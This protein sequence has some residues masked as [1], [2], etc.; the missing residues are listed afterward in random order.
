MVGVAKQA[1]DLPGERSNDKVPIVVNLTDE[2]DT[3]SSFSSILDTDGTWEIESAA[4]RFDVYEVLHVDEAEASMYKVKTG[5][6]EASKEIEQ[7]PSTL[8]YG[9]MHDEEVDWGFDDPKIEVDKEIQLLVDRAMAKIQ[10]KKELSLFK[11]QSMAVQA[12]HEDEPTSFA[13]EK[14]VKPI[15]EE[16]VA[17]MDI[18]D[19]DEAAEH[20]DK[21]PCDSIFWFANVLKIQVMNGLQ[22]FG[23]GQCF[24]YDPACGS[25]MYAMVA[26]RPDIA[27]AVGVVSRFMSIPGKKHWDAVKSILIPVVGG[28]LSIKGYVDSDYAGCVDSRKSTTEENSDVKSHHEASKR[29]N[30]NEQI[31]NSAA[32][33]RRRISPHEAKARKKTKDTRGKSPV[34]DVDTPATSDLDVHPKRTRRTPS[35]SPAYGRRSS[36]SPYSCRLEESEKNVEKKR[37]KKKPSRVDVDEL[38][39]QGATLMDKTIREFGYDYWEIVTLAP[40][41]VDNFKELTDKFY[42]EHLHPYD[43][44]CIILE[45]NGYSD[46]PDYDG[47]MIS[48]SVEKGDMITLPP[49]IVDVDELQKQGATLIDKTIREFGYDNWEIVT[50]APH[51]VDNFKELTDK[52]YHEHLHPYDESRIILEGNGYWDIPDYDGTMIS[53][54]VEKGDMITLPPGI[55][56][57]DE[58]QKQGA[59]LI[60]KTIREF[61]YDYWEIVTLAPHL[62]DNFKELTDKFYHEHL[63]PYDESRIILEGNGYWDIL[64]YDGT[65]IR[66]SVEKGDMITLPPGIVD[67]DELQKQGATLIDKTIR[68]FGYDYWEIVTLAPHLVDNF[69][70]LTD[71][72]YHEH[73][74]S[75]DESRIILEGNGKLS[76]YWDIPDYDGTMIRFSVK[77]GD[78]ITLP[79]GMYHRFT[80]DTNDYIKAMLLF[81]EVPER[82]DLLRPQGDDIPARKEYFTKV[83]K[84]PAA[85]H[86]QPLPIA[87]GRDDQN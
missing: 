21:L 76:S 13:I 6:F 72:F 49:G 3:M 27:H 20:C 26:T 55:V 78:M 80:M 62:V 70:E 17:R 39:K 14:Q 2:D 65:M 64:D 58:L 82:I 52:F 69:K 36:R 8:N 38:Q 50:L 75:Y 35:P 5:L 34:Y 10:V 56:D 60:D 29:R 4:S 53:F 59:T 63:H 31:K 30:S 33:R 79:P 22:V 9:N 87:N 37:R 46:I 61:G 28:E 16:Q 45:G 11:G 23:L 67:V 86:R 71:K 51:L 68:E 44:S 24:L 19:K 74:H 15:V 73:L 25:L 43:E 48:F 40:L 41:L 77:K 57:V 7:P 47:T 12:I 18:D 1:E 32:T 42:H 66:F 54:S 81:K 84:N 85:H 83:L